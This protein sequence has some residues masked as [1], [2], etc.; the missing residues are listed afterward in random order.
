MKQQKR[1]NYQ[2]LLIWRQAGPLT[3]GAH[4]CASKAG[5]LV[6]TKVFARSLAAQG[7]TVNAVAPAA[8]ETPEMEKMDQVVLD[9][10]KMNIPVNR[11]G[12][13]EEVANMVS[14]LASDAADILLVQ[15]LI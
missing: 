3:S 15:H 10:M 6:L 2:C 14:Y 9:K 12:K 5:Q 1:S 13:A 11:F 8:I 4:Y 7:I